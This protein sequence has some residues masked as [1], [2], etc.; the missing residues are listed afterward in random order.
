MRRA[1]LIGA[2]GLGSFLAGIILGNVVGEATQ[3]PTYIFTWIGLA[4]LV[5]A[6]VM[7]L[8]SRRG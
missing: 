2:L 8:K 3:F 7:G 4:L 5:T 6:I 1:V